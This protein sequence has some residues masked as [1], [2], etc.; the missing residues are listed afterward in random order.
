MRQL[1]R[2][3]LELEGYRRFAR[4][5]AHR[6]PLAELVD[7]IAIPSETGPPAAVFAWQRPREILELLIDLQ[8][9]PPRVIVEIGTAAGGTLLLLARVA[10]PDALLVSVDLRGGGYGG[11]YSP[12]RRRIYRSFARERQR[13]VL[14]DG[15][16]H[17]PATRDRLLKHLAGRQIDFL[18][19][20]GDHSYD[21]VRRDFED[22]AP[23]VAPGGQVCLHDI[24]QH[25]LGYSGEVWRF[26]QELETCRADTRAILEPGVAGYGL[27]LIAMRAETSG[28]LD[29]AG[30]VLASASLPSSASRAASPARP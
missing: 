18:F 29:G 23:L 13:I 14:I 8:A 2:R 7:R 27:G 19:I 4:G 5:E 22:Y 28:R 17:S 11:G 9:V 30:R 24:R 26:W 1:W 12:W 21:G 20:D 3:F 15:D 25:P 6:M 10:A 16:S